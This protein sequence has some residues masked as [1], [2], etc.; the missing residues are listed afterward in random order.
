MYLCFVHKCI[1]VKVVSVSNEQMKKN[2]SSV[3]RSQK[4]NYVN[5][6]VT[7]RWDEMSLSMD[8]NNVFDDFRLLMVLNV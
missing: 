1:L 7:L 8:D 6:K 3:T 4:L 2:C 5:E